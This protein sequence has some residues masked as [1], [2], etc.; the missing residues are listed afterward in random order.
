M[1]ILALD[2]ASMITGWSIFDDEKLVAYGKLEMPKGSS[3]GE[4]LVIIRNGVKALIDEYQ[5]TYVGFEDI[6]MQTSVGNN[7]QTFKVLAEVFG[8]ILMLCTELKIDYTIVSSNTWKSTLEIKGK[9]RAEQKR[10]AQEYVVNTY[11][12]KPT[13]DEAD[14]ICIGAHM[15][16][17]PGKNTV[18]FEEGFNW[19]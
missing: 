11:G 3:V 1:K 8:V 2:Q 10:N 16:H 9:K 6:Q 17:H 7:V 5:I 12:V 18:V 14:A 19:E 13:Q 4:R 15:I